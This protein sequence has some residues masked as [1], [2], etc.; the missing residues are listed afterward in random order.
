MA[1]MKMNIEMPTRLCVVN[2]RVGHFHLWERYS[3]PIPAS[4]MIGGEPA[5]IFSRVYGIVEFD[6]SVQRVDPSE[7]KFRDEDTDFL[8]RINSTEEFRNRI[9]QGPKI[10]EKV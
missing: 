8:Y 7:I 4:P 10:K 9:I 1:E 2:D 3:T 5:G 6:D